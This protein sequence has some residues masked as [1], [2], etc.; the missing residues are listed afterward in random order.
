MSDTVPSPPLPVDGLVGLD[1][2]KWQGKID[3]SKVP[4]LGVR[5][6]VAKCTHGSTGVDSQFLNNREGIR[7]S[8]ISFGAYHWFLPAQDPIKQAQHFVE[9]AGALQDGDIGLAVDF[10]EAQGL[11][12]TALLDPLVLHLRE[13]TRLTGRRPLLY[14]G[15]WFWTQHVQNLDSAECAAYPLWVAM[16]PSTRRD[17]REYR[18][19]VLSLP[20]DVPVP[21]PWSKRGLQEAIWQFDGDGGLFLTSTVDV[22]V[23]RLRDGD[24]EGLIQN[25]YCQ[26]PQALPLT[27]DPSE[28]QRA[29]NGL[30]FS[31][32]D[33]DGKVGPKTKAALESYKVARGLNAQTVRA[34]LE[35]EYVELAAC[36]NPPPPA[37]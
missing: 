36:Q 21:L 19:A 16:Y 11:T 33:V 34:A 8:G 22:D 14:T 27:L 15:S 26:D 28:L 7:A 32:G 20:L 25:T 3:W 24:L 9:T 23:N 1:V 35:K 12:G 17:A 37:C 18:D 13:V 6:A 5:W 10:E 31:V 2:S 29:L 30:G 4:A